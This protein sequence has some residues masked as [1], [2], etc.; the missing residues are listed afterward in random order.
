MG[1]ARLDVLLVEDKE[2]EARVV[3]RW[4]EA[5]ASARVVIASN[6]NDAFR[7]LDTRRR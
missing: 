1:D 4:I 7:E 3:A 2:L 6:G 5:K